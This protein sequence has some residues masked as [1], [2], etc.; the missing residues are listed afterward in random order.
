[1]AASATL[2]ATNSR[3]R[4]RRRS[5][6]NWTNGFLAVIPLGIFAASAT[7]IRGRDGEKPVNV[8]RLVVACNCAKRDLPRLKSR[9]SSEEFL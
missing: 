9:L 1:M 6:A 7:A 3:A 2:Y 5:A 8:I 4:G